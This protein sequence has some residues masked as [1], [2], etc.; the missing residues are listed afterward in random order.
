MLSYLN[1]FE[2]TVQSPNENYARELLELFSLGVD[3]LYTQRDVQEVA[4]LFT[5][6]SVGWVESGPFDPG[7]DPQFIRHPELPEFPLDL[8]EPRPLAAPTQE[9][10]DDATHVWA[11]V[12]RL[13]DHD[14]GRKELFLAEYGGTDSLGNPLADSDQLRIIEN[15]GSRTVGSAGDEIDLLLYRLVGFRDCRKL[16][17]SEL[18]QLFVTD[19]LSDLARTGPAPAEVED[20]FRRI[21]LDSNGAIDRIEWSEPVPLV[22]PNGR[23][24]EIFEELDG[25]GDGGLTLLE[26][27]EPDLLL[28]A[29]KRWE[30]T[31]GDIRETLRVILLSDEFLSLKFQK[32]KVK[33]PLEQVASTLRVLHATVS[34]SQLKQAVQDMSYAGMDLFHYPNPS[35]ES[36][37]GFDWLDTVGLLERIKWINRGANPASPD[38][39]RFSWSPLSFTERY[40]LSSR[41]SLADFFI[42][43][44][45]PEGLAENERLLALEAYDESPGTAVQ[46]MVAFLLSIAPAMKQ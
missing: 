35:G 1:G 7:N 9:F 8:R 44:L 29:M 23:P 17:C 31:G 28:A 33:T 24:P 22:L 27:R 2:N 43:L 37:L 42:R 40:E 32:A 41:E 12:I 25:D 5:G 15:T 36:E 16:I 6:L 19:D 30:E 34:D 38:Q 45:H 4:R 10:W 26:Y 46:A 11:S 21:D 39:R 14:W 18:I 20:P 13:G 3:H